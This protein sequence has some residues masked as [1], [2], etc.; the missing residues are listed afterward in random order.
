[1]P[2]VVDDALDECDALADVPAFVVDF[3][4]ADDDGLF[5]GVDEAVDTWACAEAEFEQLGR[6]VSWPLFFADLLGLG[7]VL[8]DVVG[9]ADT[10]PPG[11]ALGVTL[12]LGLGLALP[13]GLVLALAVLPLLVLPLEDVAG[14]VVVAVVLLGELLLV[15][16]AD[17]R[18]DSDGQALDEGGTTTAALLAGTPPVAEGVGEIELP[19]PSVLGG[20]LEELPVMAELRASVTVRNPWRAGGT[21]DRTTPT[22]NT[23]APTAKAGR[24][25]ASRQSLGRFGSRR[26]GTG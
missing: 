3:A 9:V 17:G 23:A 16:V 1:V 12:P 20:P 15:G 18:V 13:D 14:A 22:A 19:W 6:A 21:T 25:M 24:S 4:L 10:E 2:P 5:V 11:L 7:L 8:E 26:R